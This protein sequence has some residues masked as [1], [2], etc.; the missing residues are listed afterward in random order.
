MSTEGA[1]PADEG[2]V[3]FD[4]QAPPPPLAEL[5]ELAAP[6]LKAAPHSTFFHVVALLERL[7]KDAARVGGDGPPSAERIRF[8]HG[9]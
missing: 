6:V 8:R 1:D 2:P 5:I 4:S 7:T 3:T 9:P